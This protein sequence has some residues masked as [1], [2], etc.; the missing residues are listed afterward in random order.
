MTPA[1]CIVLIGVVLRIVMEIKKRR[2]SSFGWLNVTQFFGALNDNVFKLMVILFIVNVVVGQEELNS[3][4]ALATLIFVIPFLLFS[5]AAGVMADRFSK[6]NIVVAAKWAE[7]LIMIASV[8]ALRLGN[9]YVLYTLLFVMCT[10]SAFFGPSKYGIIPELVGEHRLSQSNS[11]LVALSYLAIIIG[12]FLPS[13]FL[14]FLFEGNYMI[15]GGFCVVI[16]GLGLLASRRIEVT[17]AVGEHKRLTPFFVVDIFK[18]LFSLRK[19]RYLHLAV[20]GS[21]YFLFLGVFIQ[22]ALL[23]YGVDTLGLSAAKSAYFFPMAALGIGLGALVAGKLSG[24]NIEIGVVPIGAIGLTLC[25]VAMNWMPATVVALL[26]VVFLLGVSSGL[27]IVPLNAFIQHRAPRERRGEILACC[28]FMSFLG[29]AISAGVFIVLA[30]VFNFTPGQCFLVV[31][32]LTAIMAGL[33]LWLLPDFLIRLF[34]VLITKI[35][36]RIKSAGLEN[37]PVTGGALLI[38]NHVTWVDALLIAATQQRRVLYM[39][40]RSIYETW[41]INPLFRLMKVIPVSTKDNPRLIIESLR[42]AREALKDGYMVCIFAEGT[43]TRNGNMREFR[44]GFERIVKGTDIPI[45]P[46]YLGGAWGSIFSHYHGKLLS[47]FPRAIPYPVSVL[48]GKPLPPTAPPSEVRV[49]VCEL[50]SDSFDMRKSRKRTLNASFVKRARSY[51]F[52]RA[53]SDSD[54]KK[55]S[56]GKTLT[57]A[58]ALGMVLRKR[59]DAAADPLDPPRC[60]Q[61]DSDENSEANKSSAVEMVGVVMPASI[62]GAL[63]NLAIT[64]MGKIPVNLNFTA[65]ANSVASAIEQCNIKTIVSSRKFVEKLGDRFD[66]PEGTL[67]I[68]DLMPQI[69]TGVRV[70]ALFK[71]RFFTPR[72]LA[73][74]R[75]IESDD[76]ATI[77]FSSGS[78]ADPKGVML[79][80]HNLISNVEAIQLVFRFE[81]QDR[82][83]AVLPF[84]H[85]FGLTA[86]LWTPMICG[87]AACYHP[88]PLDGA[89]IG[90]MVRE[91]G[92]TA[93]VATPTFLLSYVRR[94]GEDD[95]KTL[96]AVMTGAEKLKPRI[97]DAFEKKFGIRP[98]EGYGATELS[99]VGAMSQSNISSKAVLQDGSN[100][101]RSEQV[102]VKEGSVGHPVPGVAA[103]I[104][105]PD[106]LELLSDNSEGLLLIKGPNVMMGY[107]GQKEKTAEVL[108]DGWYNTGDIAR[109]DS[110]GFVF[111]LDRLSRYSKIG[112]EMVPH[113]AIEDVLIDGLNAVDPCVV[114]TAAPDERKGEQI[115][116]CFT[117]AA[118]SAS[119]LQAI[120]KASDIPNLWKPKRDNYIHIDKIPTL[121]TGK[122][123]LKAIKEIAREFV[124]VRPGRV[125][126]VLGKI[127]GE[128]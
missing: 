22:Q 81:P 115:I 23:Y 29:A 93:I 71:A 90:E 42:T 52:R 128:R 9:P 62:G 5:H 92:L 4:Q 1:Y 19:D 53:L 13:F 39:M 88:N 60:V 113:M 118:E 68:E 98:V 80:H 55:M 125:Q 123:D 59:L 120:I 26:L 65:S 83:C 40:E 85:S 114:V 126:R 106:S 32:V 57:G 82:F 89:I 107:L 18:T 6:R 124:E 37:V 109:I 95:F 72:A 14:D 8:A 31:G 61:D 16:A 64:L 70:V 11:F 56:F 30:R 69:T 12:T 63:I 99:P 15:L 3:T 43:L 2:M 45:I 79:S 108:K 110:D 111:L 119:R 127:R 46:V 66:V 21:A 97:A 87:F 28:N 91:N 74:G 112:G 47:S 94:A 38:S 121:G 36:Y 103:R 58:I 76:L 10:Q 86:T 84:F 48:F 67:F 17:P 50:S 49:A 35:F 33:T 122:L 101:I 24:R 102:G 44:G 96:R 41:W 117:D 27:Y 104:V 116:V 51:W 78:T 75:R 25:C 54:G 7:F 20:I 100:Q 34:V 105:D 77:I 73:H